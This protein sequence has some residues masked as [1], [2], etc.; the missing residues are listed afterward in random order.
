MNRMMRKSTYREIR[1][2]LGRFMAILAIIALGVG[3]FAGLKVTKPFMLET[4]DT[5]LK[6]KKFYDFQLL[7]N[8]GFEDEDVAYLASQPDIRAVEGGFSM[9][10]L[11]QYGDFDGIQVMKVHSMTEG[12]NEVLVLSGRLPQ[13]A[14]ECVVDSR[15]FGEEAIGHT[16]RLS[17]TNE[18]DTLDKFV[19]SEFNIVGIVNASYYF[20]MERGNTSLGS[21]TVNGFMYVLPE[22]FDSEVYTEVWVKLNQDFTLYSDEYEVY[23]EQ[24]QEEWEIYAE[25]AAENR[26]QRILGEANQ[27]LAEAKEEFAT[28][29]ADAE[30]ELKEAE[31]ELADAAKEIED[32]KIEITDAKA[33]IAD[34]YQEIKE[35][36]QELKDGEA[37]LKE[38]EQTLLEKEAELA[39][40]LEEW[41]DAN[42]IVESEKHELWEQEAL[43][44]EQEEA[45][46]TQ[47]EELLSQETQFEAMIQIPEYYP[48]D[49]AVAASRVEFAAGKAQLAEGKAQIEEYKDKID[50]GFDML[51]EADLELAESW[52]ELEDGK[53][54]IEDAKVEIADAKAEIADGKRK[55]ADAKQELADAEAELADAEIELADGEAEYLDGLKEYEEGVEEFNIEI[56]DAEA[57]IA[58]AEAEIADMEASESYVLD[59]NTN[60]GYV[61]L[62]NDSQI[63]ADVS[64]VFPVFFFLVAAL[65]CMTTMN[66]MVEEQR[67]QIGVLK[68]L[69][70]SD[71]AIMAKYLF[72]AGS[73][74]LV[75][76]ICGFILGT[77]FLPKVIWTAYGTM[78]NM[79]PLNYYV[80]W[81]MAVISLVASLTCS[82]GVTWYSCRVELG[83]VAASLMRPKA[84]K[85]GKRIFLERIPFFWKKFKFLQKVS[86]R[87]VL[88]YKKR[89]FM[90]TIGISGCTALLVAGFGIL[91][92][93]KEVVAMQYRE[94]QLYD[95]STTFGEQPDEEMWDI[96]KQI[97]ENWAK[98][99]DL[100]MET[101]MDIAFQEEIKSVSLIVPQD[102]DSFHEYVDLHSRDGEKVE[103]PKEG[104]VVINYKLAENLGIQIGDT[105]TLTD[106]EQNSFSV[107]VSGINQN[108]VFSYI[109]LHPDTCINRWKEPEY[110]TAYLNCKEN[111]QDIHLLSAELMDLEEV[112][113]VT[114][115]QDVQE[116]FENMMSSMNYIVIVI[117]LCAAALAFI[118]LYNLTNINITERIREIATIKVL[119]FYKKETATY[120]FRENLILT[121]IGAGVGLLLGKVF[122]AFIMSCINI[123]MVAFDV[124]VEKIS[125]LYS[126]LLTFLFAWFVNRFMTGKIDRIS[127]T[128]SLKSVD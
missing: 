87:N 74:A 118:V 102:V 59:R 36:E 70:Y 47:E 55:I 63:V 101:A 4:A 127:M 13:N 111:Q 24:K 107:T 65:V 96:Y 61:C 105:V 126:F 12:I 99:T 29:K 78:Y 90:M 92:S 128:E 88:R 41:R 83:E 60:V 51:E 114:V 33:E 77:Y 109:F 86:I 45:L 8:Y 81:T 68:A 26:F 67:T 110:K 31:A 3:L 104:E 46:Q 106:D 14:E 43:L 125:Y 71:G 69:G 49:E 17:S 120:V 10:V 72:Y 25:T 73:A 62:E 15:L 76:C 50:Y 11:Y 84:P 122:H 93:V 34:A 56:A 94:I 35:K 98:N 28:E 100:A 21:G 58:E 85:A 89:F 121:A 44:A 32:A 7:S 57:E 38:N 6:E 97:V 53:R 123:E 16:I 75:G 95:M 64:N 20:Q 79:V 22:V 18:E 2:S 113:N 112:A 30:A 103:F 124:R 108:F 82:M 66:R 52:Q 80:D 23:I 19:K 54:Q 5:Y 37:T 91:D 119:G 27:E 39:E 9:D 48:G 117:I 40:G 116:R 115:N 42:Y 1:Q